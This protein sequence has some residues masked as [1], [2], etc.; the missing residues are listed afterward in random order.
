MLGNY[1]LTAWRQLRRNKLHSFINIS[2]LAIGM[3][4]AML[5]GLWIWDE[6]ASNNWHSRHD[7]LAR[8]LS[9]ERTNSEVTVAAVASVPMEA[10]TSILS[11]QYKY[12]LV[13]LFIFPRKLILT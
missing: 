12:T 8:I 4:V 10:E 6:L 13:F 3:A 9:I 7:S 1:L 11:Y 2:D 5:I